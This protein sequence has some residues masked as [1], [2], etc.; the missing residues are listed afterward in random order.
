MTLQAFHNLVE[1]ANDGMAIVQDT[2]V[3]YVNPRMA[4]MMGYVVPE[5][6]NRPFI[7]YIHPDNRQEVFNY[8]SRSIVGDDVPS[9]YEAALLHRKGHKIPVEVN[10]RISSYEGSPA[11]LVVL[12][13]PI[14]RQRPVAALTESEKSLKDL[15]D[16]LQ[17]TVFECN[18][19]GDVTFANRHAL[20][21]TGYTEEDLDTGLNALQFF[22]PEDRKR[23]KNNIARMLGGET[24]GTNEYTTMGKDGMRLLIMLESSSIMCGERP[25]EMRGILTNII[26]QNAAEEAIRELE[27]RYRFLFENSH[28]AIFIADLKTHRILEANRQAERLMGYSREEIIGM[29]Q[30][31][32]HPPEYKEYYTEK[33]REH[34]RKGSVFDLEAEITKRDQGIVPVAI[35]ASVTKYQGKEVIHGLFTDLSTEKRLFALKEELAARKLIERAKGILMDRHKIDE[36][37]AMSR[38]Q[39]ESR[40]QSKKIKEIARSVISSESIF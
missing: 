36:K 24:V 26:E 16:V 37:K 10:A 11:G 20:K 32:L 1:Q 2:L 27:E 25:L 15:A 33:F 39:R 9:E 40:K 14:E 35:R 17:Q 21:C 29:H 7:N 12:R 8:Y 13:Y 23:I 5:V 31:Q 4:G 30:S 22:V 3:K 38:L 28:D 6:L 19:R 18:E 34:V